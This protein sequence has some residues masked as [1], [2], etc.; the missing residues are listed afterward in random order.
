MAEGNIDDILVRLDEIEKLQTE[1]R[2]LVP[3]VTGNSSG[4]RDLS[5]NSSTSIRFPSLLTF[6]VISNFSSTS[7]KTERVQ[8]STAQMNLSNR[9]LSGTRPSTASLG[10]SQRP[11]KRG[12][13]AKETNIFKD[14]LKSTSNVTRSHGRNSLASTSSVANSKVSMMPYSTRSTTAS[15]KEELKNERSTTAMGKMQNATD[16]RLS[17]VRLSRKEIDANANRD[18]R[19]RSAHSNEIGKHVVVP[20]KKSM[21]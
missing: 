17:N 20:K 3:R 14:L 18:T 4:H 8:K 15:R 19:V 13:S 6:P 12:S 2:H 16:G 5:R 21:S 7:S 11:A 9:L 10:N 1:L